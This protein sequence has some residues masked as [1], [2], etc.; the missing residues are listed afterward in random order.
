MGWLDPGCGWL[1]GTRVSAM[2][3]FWCDLSDEPFASER[4]SEFGTSLSPQSLKKNQGSFRIRGAEFL[5]HTTDTGSLPL[6]ADISVQRQ[7]GR[8]G[9]DSRP[10]ENHLHLRHSGQ[11]T[12]LCGD[13]DRQ[14]IKSV[15]VRHPDQSALFP[16]MTEAFSQS[17]AS[18]SVALANQRCSF[19]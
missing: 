18:P 14:S 7:S 2:T 1:Y 19:S 6:Y 9:R 3:V 13:Q 8:G 15:A 5:C 12:S 16:V 4:M 10:C 11:S 17:E